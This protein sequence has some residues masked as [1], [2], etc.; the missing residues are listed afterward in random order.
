MT[1]SQ[2][3]D[4]LFKD[5][6]GDE[7]GRRAPAVIA[8]LA[9]GVSALVSMID[10]ELKF[11]SVLSL[12]AIAVFFP[13]ALY[14][15]LKG[16]YHYAAFIPITGGFFMT[17][18]SLSSGKGTHDAAWF[19]AIGASV[20]LFLFVSNEAFA[21]LLSM[22]FGLLFLGVGAAEIYNYVPNPYHTAW[23]YVG[24]KIAT[25][26]SIVAL[27]FYIFR[28]QKNLLRLTRDS[29]QAQIKVNVELRE[30]NQTLENRVEERTHDMQI[31]SQVSREI[32]QTLRLEE[33]LPNL[34]EKT[35]AG[36]GL[37]FA[38]VYLYDAESQ[39]LLLEAGTGEA[40]KQ[41]KTG[42]M[43]YNVLTHPSLAAQA[44]RERQ[45]LMVASAT[46][47]DAFFSN[48]YLP[49]TKSEAAVPMMIYDELVG[50]LD[51]QS[52]KLNRFSEADMQTLTALAG[53]IAVAIQNARLYEEQI[54]TAEKLRALDKLKSEFLASMSHEIRTPMNGII[55]M[56]G[57]ILDTPLNA[58]Q[59][60]Y[61][62]MIRNSGDSLLTIINDILDFSKIEAGKLDMENQPFDLRDC[63]ESALDLLAL[64]ATA[65]GIELGCVIEPDVPAAIMGD[66][67]RL[68]QIAVNLLSNAVKFTKR[69]EIVLTVGAS[70]RSDDSAIQR[71]KYSAFFIQHSSFLRPR[72]RHRHF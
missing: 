24:N 58:E 51:L 61:A 43:A 57:L 45:A 49:L 34:V 41:M 70:Q 33:L 63:L 5:L 30:L 3:R 11:S 21:A 56:T 18:M 52:E 48:P 68:R 2:I 53:Q 22:L 13:L 35:K 14:H 55:G 28:R 42:K 65:N 4:Y 7:P 62:D 26:V 38:S 36:Y 29:E 25:D 47:S 23:D 59:R 20:L 32:T 9:V 17:F 6:P 12:I 66:V 15:I 31:A 19:G 46:T 27:L 1:F 72:H 10:V 37:Y 69:G 60:E 71:I 64:K 8:I 44:G 67:T 54:V 39:R 16:R 50:V 40:G